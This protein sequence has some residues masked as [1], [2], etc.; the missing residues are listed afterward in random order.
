MSGKEEKVIRRWGRKQKGK[1]AFSQTRIPGFLHLPGKNDLLLS[2][3]ANAMAWGGQKCGE[4]GTPSFKDGNL[5]LP[6]SPQE[7]DNLQTLGA[8]EASS[9][10][11]DWKRE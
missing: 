6:G 11:R 1:K 4:L 5:F 3:P 9:T 7:G 10:K 2:S 8:A